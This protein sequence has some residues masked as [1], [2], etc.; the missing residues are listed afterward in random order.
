MVLAGKKEYNTGMWQS[1]KNIYH[2]FVAVL[3]NI[4]YG[5]PGKRLTVIGVTGTDGKTT[6]VNLIY[7]ILK[8]A[9]YSVS[10]VSTVGAVIHGKTSAI[11]FHVTTPSSLM[12]Q[13][14]LKQAA[15]GKGKQYLVLE[16]TSHALDQNR[17][18]GIPFLIGV[19]TNIT[20]EHLD[21]H[22]TYANYVKTK[23]KLLNRADIAIV[24]QDDHSY[25]KVKYFLKHDK[26]VVTY[27]SHNDANVSLSDIKIPHSIPQ[28]YNKYNALAASIAAM[29]V[30]VEKKV[31][32]KALKTFTFPK[33]RTEIVYDKDFTVMI[34]FAHTPNA[35]EQLLSSVKEETKGRL[36]HVFGSAGA[37][38]ISKRPLMGN[39]AS[40][41]DDIVVLTS[42]DPRK[43]HPEKIMTEIENGMD[44][45]ERVE[46]YR[47]VDRKTA[48][49]KAIS[50]AK[51][52]D[53]VVCTGKGHEESINYGNG[54]EPWNEFA[55]ITEALKVRSS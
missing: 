18:W 3:A 26:K 51:K 48:I 40:R 37:R 10:M 20:H 36:I 30:G 1:I 11:G 13:K 41:Y 35:F 17:V 21:Y 45:K 15:E 34:D 31:V 42:E 28:L 44:K 52:G 50:L 6:T 22:K 12:L 38:D 39:I 33:G 5:F 49:K 55:V 16:V 9:G 2:L 32:E 43:E 54:E 19:L 25:H 23:V 4:F 53:L 24:N 27:G 8:E 7:H 47:I 46:I 29:Q 14:F